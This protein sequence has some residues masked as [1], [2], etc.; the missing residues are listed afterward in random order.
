MSQHTAPRSSV[1]PIATMQ[2]HPLNNIVSY[3]PYWIVQTDKT[4]LPS[5]GFVNQKLF[6]CFMDLTIN[7]IEP[8]PL[9]HT[10]KLKDF[11]LTN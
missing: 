6:W 5:H 10:A 11:H 1:P 8:S 9:I 3:N 2:L 4:I 7:E